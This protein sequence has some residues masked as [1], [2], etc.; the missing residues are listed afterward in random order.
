LVEDVIPTIRR[1]GE[2]RLRLE[3]DQLQ[4]KLEQLSLHTYYLPPDKIYNASVIGA[5]SNISNQKCL[6]KLQEM[7]YVTRRDGMNGNIWSPTKIGKAYGRRV[8]N[9]VLWSKRVHIPIM[10]KEGYNMSKY[11][12]AIKLLD[13]D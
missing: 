6:R 11:R 5:M 4:Q 3:N 1:T 12:E 10:E 9:Y 13:K 2:Y 8:S 7:G